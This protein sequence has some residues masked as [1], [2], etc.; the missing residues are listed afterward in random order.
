ML[1]YKKMEELQKIAIT[2]Y[3]LTISNSN[4]KVEIKYGVKDLKRKMER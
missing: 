2:L 3:D 1:K 4:T